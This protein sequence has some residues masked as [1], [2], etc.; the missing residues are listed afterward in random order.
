MLTR[1]DR[2][3]NKGP[4]QM[5]IERDDDNLS[6]NSLADAERDLKKPLPWSHL[7]KKPT[8]PTPSISVRSLKITDPTKDQ[9]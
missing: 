6:K 4:I 3:N 1:L 5:G 2:N 7:K 8:K 9:S